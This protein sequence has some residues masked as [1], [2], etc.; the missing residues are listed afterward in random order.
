MAA[1]GLAGKAFDQSGRAGDAGEVVGI[2]LEEAELLAAF[3]R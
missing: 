1:P 3:S 2:M